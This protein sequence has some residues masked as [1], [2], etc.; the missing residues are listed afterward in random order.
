M[1]KY[2]LFVYLQ[3]LSISIISQSTFQIS[4]ESGKYDSSFV[5]NISGDFRKVYYTLDGSTPSYSSKKW[6]D[7]LSFKMEWLVTKT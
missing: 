2:R 4:H 5:L 3:L 1:V 6:K 7:S